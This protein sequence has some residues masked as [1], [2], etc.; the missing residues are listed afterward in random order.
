M[1]LCDAAQSMGGK[2]YILGGGWTQIMLVDPLPP[3]ALAVQ[4]TVPWDQ[5]NERMAVEV[6]LVTEDGK[7]VDFGSGPVA[8]GGEMEVGRPPGLRRGTPLDSSL[9][10]NFG[11]LRLNPGGYVWELRVDNDAKARTPFRV[12]PSQGPGVGL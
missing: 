12:L 5:A 7:P 4:L 11:G 8:A 10:M 9:V 3:M 6:A 1:M 2:L